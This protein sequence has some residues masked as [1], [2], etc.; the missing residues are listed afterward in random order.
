M[1]TTVLQAAVVTV[2]ILLVEWPQ[3]KH[4]SKTTRWIT[5]SLLGVSGIIWVYVFSVAHVLRPAAV[6]ERLL[7]PFDPFS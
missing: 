5:F 2:F 4:A 1:I 3:L 6:L 7:K